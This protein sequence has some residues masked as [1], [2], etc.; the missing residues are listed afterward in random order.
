MTSPLR[1]IPL[2]CGDFGV[3]MKASQLIKL[4]E[5]DPDGEVLVGFEEHVQ[6][7]DLT[8]GTEDCIDPVTAVYKD[9]SKFVISAEC[10]LTCERIWP[11][12]PSA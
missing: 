8:S 4:L 2:L 5:T 10:Y 1:L 12:K 11:E 3:N 7:S 9:G 6:Y